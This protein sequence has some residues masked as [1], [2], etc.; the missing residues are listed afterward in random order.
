MPDRRAGIKRAQTQ[1][2]VF[3]K[4]APAYTSSLFSGKGIVIM[5]GG[6]TYFV[7]AWINIHMLRKTGRFAGQLCKGAG[8][9]FALLT[10]F[11]AGVRLYTEAAV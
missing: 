7:P 3:Q 6:L 10:V 9:T 2:E 8:T 11:I 4:N 5:A 1:L